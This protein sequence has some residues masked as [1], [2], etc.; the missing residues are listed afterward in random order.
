MSRLSTDPDFRKLIAHER[1]RL[2][3]LSY[4][5]VKDADDA[6]DIVQETLIAIW[7]IN[8]T[9]KIRNLHAYAKRAVWI[10]SIRHRKR[11]KGIDFINFD[12]LG[13][14]GLAE[15]AVYHDLD[16]ELTSWEL[17]DAIRELPAAQQTVIRLRFYS[18]L[19][20]IEIGRA[21]SISL[22][23]AASRCRYALETLRDILHTNDMED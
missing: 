16:R 12:E 22:N 6:E 1:V 15:P 13:K 14:K 18:S 21:L 4:S 5:I 2:I 7:K 19:S 20:F 23:T 10:N 3:R 8:K 11:V 17:E 9:E